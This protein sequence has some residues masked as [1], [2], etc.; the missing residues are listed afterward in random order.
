LS[1]AA[2]SSAG[3][4]TALT[5]SRPVAGSFFPLNYAAQKVLGFFNSA[6]KSR[7]TRSPWAIDRL[8]LDDGLTGTTVV[9]LVPP[10]IQSMDMR[11][12]A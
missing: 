4:R 6:P 2:V 5:G 1:T 3:N 8:R 10:Q 7:L 9:K 11:P 12:V